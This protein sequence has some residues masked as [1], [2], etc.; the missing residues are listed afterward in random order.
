VKSDLVLSLPDRKKILVEVANPKDP[1]RFFGE[2][3]YPQLL[4][5]YKQI[6]AA[7]IFVLP[8]ALDYEGIHTTRI[9]QTGPVKQV[10]KRQIPCMVISWPHKEE[11][12][13]RNL[14]Y[15]V[16]NYHNYITKDMPY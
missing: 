5:Y 13:Y 9:F 12:S 8:H 3:I 14:K 11:N 7:M 1:K 16:K 6:V 2:I 10:I 4:G 15:F